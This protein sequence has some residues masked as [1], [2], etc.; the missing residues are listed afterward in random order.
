ML[1]LDEHNIALGERASDLVGHDMVFRPIPAYMTAICTGQTHP[2][3]M[4]S[5]VVL[6]VE[7]F[8]LCLSQE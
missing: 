2:C 3:E 5:C 1:I 7:S 8:K 4:I 6:I